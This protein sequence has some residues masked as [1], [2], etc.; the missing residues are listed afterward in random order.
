MIASHSGH[1][2]LVT[3]LLQNC[4][5]ETNIFVGGTTALYVACSN[6]RRDDAHEEIVLEIVQ[7]LMGAKANVNRPN[8]GNG[9][10]PFIIAIRNGYE[11]VVDWMLETK[12]PLLELWDRDQ[13][14]A[15]LHAVD[16]ER[17]NI[18]KKLIALGANT[19][20]SNR[21]NYT[22]CQLAIQK[23]LTEIRGLFP[24]YDLRHVPIECTSMNSYHDYVPT[25]F[26]ER[27]V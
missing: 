20:V 23:N 10:T 22:P 24:E 18:V 21:E 25:A 27:K 3:Y 17:F 6:D 12:T 14:T 19:D 5:A 9:E 15:I 8:S 13:N 11:R 1:L 4:S 26:P 16:A 7:L 2:S